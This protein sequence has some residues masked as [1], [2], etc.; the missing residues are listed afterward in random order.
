MSRFVLTHCINI[1]ALVRYPKFPQDARLLALGWKRLV[2]FV[3]PFALIAC[4]ASSTTGSSSAPRTATAELP[5]TPR[6]ATLPVPTTTTGTLLDVLF[7]QQV[8]TGDPQSY[9]AAEMGGKLIL[10][11]RCLRVVDNQSGASWL[12]IWP[13]E[14][15]LSADEGGIVI[16]NGADQVLWHVGDEVHIAGGEIPAGEDAWRSIASLHQKPPEEC[17]GPYWLVSNVQA[18]QIQPVRK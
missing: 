5:S 7:P 17:S 6:T 4:G 9:P 18:G 3:A 13:P 16:R 15:T 12:P 2:L 8:P 1:Q 10:V 14:F 11:G